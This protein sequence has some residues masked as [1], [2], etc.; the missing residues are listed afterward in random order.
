MMEHVLKTWTKP[1]NAVLE[2]RKRHEY[3][4][5]DRPYQVGDVLRLREYIVCRKQFTG[6]ELRATVTYL[7]RGPVFGIP[8]AYL[9]MSIELV[10]EG[11]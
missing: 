6:R 8:D 10:P 5:D 3:R 11:S 9:V 1:F 2:G 4:I 7:A